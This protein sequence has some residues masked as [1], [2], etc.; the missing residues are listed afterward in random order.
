MANTLSSI[1]KTAHL[2]IVL[3][4]LSA[5]IYPLSSFSQ[6]ALVPIGY[7][8]E[9]LNYQSTQQVVKG[10]KIY[11][12]TA[13]NLFS[14]DADNNAER[15]SKVNGLNDLG[16]SAIAWDDATQQLVIAYTNSN[17]DVLK[18]GA[19]KNISDVKT[20][21]VTGNKII[22]N[23]YC[24]GGFAYLCSGLG[25][26]VINLTK[27]EVKDTWFIGNNGNQVGINGLTNDGSFWYAATDEGLKKASVNAANLS[28]Y[29]NWLNLSGSN[30]LSSGAVKNIVAT[31]SKIF[32]LKNDSLLVMNG[33]NWNLFYTDIN[34]Q[35]TTVTASENKLLVCQKNAA[36]LGRVLQINSSGIIE[37]TLVN[38]TY[39]SSPKQAISDNGNVWIADAK[40]GLSKYTTSFASYIPNGP[41]GI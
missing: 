33:N 37:K 15:Y 31:N 1:M 40:Q 12:A 22:N 10:D 25:V 9:H 16:V 3:L 23:I 13:N 6:N 5:I 20:S 30:G 38:A 14:V 17:I 8:R 27:Y 21:S 7:W 41:S 28:N 39:I 19:I 36:N 24:N 4:F 11:C 2:K 32:A 26:I 35:I 18:N 34:W 29:I